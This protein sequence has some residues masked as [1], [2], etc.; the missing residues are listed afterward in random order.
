M[1]LRD[2]SLIC[3]GEGREGRGLGGWRVRAI[4]GEGLRMCR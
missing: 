3:G 2:H 1:L 4:S